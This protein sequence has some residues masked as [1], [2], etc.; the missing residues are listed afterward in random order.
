M[1]ETI[2]EE[3]IVPNTWLDEELKSIQ[4]FEG[5]E[6]LPSLKFP[7]NELL[8]VD[9][10]FSKQFNTYHDEL[11]KSIKKIIPVT[12][13]GKRMIW[14]LNCSNPIYHKVLELG[15]KG[16]THFKI[17]RTGSMKATRYTLVK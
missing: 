10:D 13:N 6:K 5:G 8:E 15:K 4:S 1:E 14:W 3:I 9:I 17:L 11:N 16:Q 7:E 2:K 12:Y